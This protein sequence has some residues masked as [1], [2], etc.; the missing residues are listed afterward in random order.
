MLNT[1]FN[2]KQRNKITIKG[3]FSSLFFVLLCVASLAAM[4]VGGR[5][6]YSISRALILQQQ[7]YMVWIFC[8]ELISIIPDII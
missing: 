2:S 6:I 1:Q 4:A 5:I 7:K 3:K 8:A